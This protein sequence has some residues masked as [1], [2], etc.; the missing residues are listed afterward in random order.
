MTR[1]RRSACRLSRPRLCWPVPRRVLSC[2][3]GPL[4]ARAFLS[5]VGTLAVMCPAFLGGRLTAGPCVLMSG[6]N[7]SGRHVGCVP[8]GL[9]N[10]SLAPGAN[11]DH[12][13]GA[14]NFP[15]SPNG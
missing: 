7:A 4:R 15:W 12:Q 5:H 9:A 3:D 8:P 10:P 14:V 6:Y 1:L 11:A 2:V 13:L